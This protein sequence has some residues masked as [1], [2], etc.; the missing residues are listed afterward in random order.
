MQSGIAIFLLCI[1]S[2]RIVLRGGLPIAD[3]RIAQAP[4]LANKIKIRVLN[5]KICPTNQILETIMG[6]QMLFYDLGV[7]PL[8]L[9]SGKRVSSTNL[10]HRFFKGL[11]R[12]RRNSKL[13][14]RLFG[15]PTWIQSL[16][17]ISYRQKRPQN[18][19]GTLRIISRVSPALKKSRHDE[20]GI[21]GLLIANPLRAS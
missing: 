19:L 3:T 17:K 8:N 12:R 2:I 20:L 14:F 15:Y 7:R 9:V 6:L 16:K 13:L 11:C 18:Y 4:A 10:I 21:R 1:P 5:L